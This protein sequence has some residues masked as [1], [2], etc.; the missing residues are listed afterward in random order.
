[1]KWLKK[2]RL[3][4]LFIFSQCDV[5]ILHIKDRRVCFSIQIAGSLQP[6]PETCNNYLFILC[7]G[8]FLP[9]VTVSSSPI[10]TFDLQDGGRKVC[11]RCD[12][13]FRVTE[14]LRGH[15]CVSNHS[16]MNSSPWVRGCVKGNKMAK[17]GL[18]RP[19]EHP[20]GCQDLSQMSCWCQDRFSILLTVSRDLNVKSALIF[21]FRVSWS[22]PASFQSS[23]AFACLPLIASVVLPEYF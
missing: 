2:E 4:E 9:S 8:V 20:S 23:L 16:G 15:M 14:A 6:G 7:C 19:Q 22:A 11:P 13:Q 17:E 10:P 18:R 5:E 3:V 12:A 21:S 1:M